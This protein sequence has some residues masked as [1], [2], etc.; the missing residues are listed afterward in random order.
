[1]AKGRIEAAG[2]VTPERKKTK[3]G[4]ET[5]RSEAKKSVLPFGGVATEIASVWRRNNRLK[6]WSGSGRTGVS[7][8]FGYVVERKKTGDEGAPPHLFR[9]PAWTSCTGQP[10]STESVPG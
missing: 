9:A 5:A 6:V 10:R 4:I 1:S 8:K 3:S 2:G 7:E